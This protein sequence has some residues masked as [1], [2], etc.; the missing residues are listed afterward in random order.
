VK[1][2]GGQGL[3]VQPTLHGLDISSSCSDFSGHDIH[4]ATLD[5]DKPIPQNWQSLYSTVRNQQHFAVAEILAS[6]RKMGPYWEQVAEL[7]RPFAIGK[8][9]RWR[10]P[11]GEMAQPEEI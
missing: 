1:L 7:A 5:Y 10:D 2:D 6:L 11:N 8:Q 9:E 4:L 3:G